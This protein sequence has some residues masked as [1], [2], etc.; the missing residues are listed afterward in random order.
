MNAALPGPVRVVLVDDS[1]PIRLLLRAV[2]NGAGDFAVVGEAEDGVAAVRLAG[3]LRPDLVLLDLLMPRMGGREALPLIRQASPA[4]RIVLLSGEDGAELGE[5]GVAADAVLPKGRPP[6]EI[7]QAVRKAAGR[8][9]GRPGGVA[10]PGGAA[11]PGGA[12]STAR[13]ALGA[14][15]LETIGKAAAHD[16]KSPLQAILGFAHLL[17]DLYG[18]R[19]DD[20]GRQFVHT[21]ITSTV[22]MAAMVEGLSVYSRG[23]AAPPAAVAV[24][25]PAVVAGA[26][27]R[28]EADIASSGALVTTDA[29]GEVVGDPAQIAAVITALVHNALTW[30]AGT[31]HRVAVRAAAGGGGAQ[32]SVED[33]GPGIAPEQR[34]RMFGL[35]VTQPGAA[36]SGAPPAA[37]A[38][39]APPAAP[40]SGAPLSGSA[41]VGLA[42]CRRLVAG[43]GGTIA[44]TD[45]AGGGTRVSFTIPEVA[46]VVPDASAPSGALPALSGEPES[47]PAAGGGAVSVAGEPAK[48][49]GAGVEARPPGVPRV[50]LV[51]DSDEHAALVAASLQQVSFELCRVNDL[52]AA[53]SALAGERFVCILL[54]LSLP[55]GEGLESLTQVLAL[56]PGIPVVVLTSRDDEALAVAAVQRGAQDYVVKGVDPAVLARAVRY[57]IER[58]SLEAQLAQQALHDPLTGLPNRTLLLARLGPALARARRTGERVAV[59]YL[60]LDGFKPINDQFGHEAGDAVLVEVARRLSSVV[61]PQDTVARMGGDEFAVLC[62]GFPADAEIHSLLA[63]MADAVANPM[64]QDQQGGARRVTASIGAAFARETDSPEDLI[65]LA[66]EAMYREKRR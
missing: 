13:P 44:I 15:D 12:A 51:E 65:R 46:P 63:R 34:E 17:E 59:L 62:D 47:A 39:G 45:G 6:G 28:M 11:Q 19:L 50:L 7:L 52:R 18:A 5:A 60:D 42:L 56:A 27:A 24:S 31:P 35:F 37:P 29:T 38:S 40:L 10:A 2:L 23:I 58:K 16:L 9:G 41:G 49:G 54:D 61:R 32:V 25:L 57:A 8:Q 4:T 30:G 22:R 21:I 48:D 14:A 3:E 20:Q 66:D 26:L 33:N 1:A 43:W 53:R 64:A 55:D 36:K